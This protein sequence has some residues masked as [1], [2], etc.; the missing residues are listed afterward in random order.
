MDRLDHS[1][2]RANSR[3][4]GL[5]ILRR[6]LL[7]AQSY[8]G[9][10]ERTITVRECIDEKV[11]STQDL[12]VKPTRR[13]L[14]VLLIGLVCA[15]S[16]QIAS[17]CLSAPSE[18]TVPYPELIGRTANIVL[19]RAERAELL[20]DRSVRYLFRTVEVLKGKPRRA[21]T[22]TLDSS[23]I[24]HVRGL[25]TDFDKHRD[26]RFWDRRESRQWNAPDCKMAPNF[27]IGRQYLLFVDK[28][29][30][31]KS[32]EQVTDPDRDRWLQ[33]TRT[34][35]RTGGTQ[36][37]FSQT[38]WEYL[39]EKRA[40]YVDQVK[41]CSRQDG[42][43]DVTPLLDRELIRGERM[44]APNLIRVFTPCREG[45]TFLTFYYQTPSRTLGNAWDFPMPWPFPM[46]WDFLNDDP[47]GVPIEDGMADFTSLETEIKIAGPARISIQELRQRLR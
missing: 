21:F 26:G 9:F 35:I 14:G 34:V 7:I 15:G 23:W 38:V 36:P 43:T 28:P 17:A 22:L 8:F 45:S 27:M 18:Q 5:G 20:P 33:A 4:H 32:F 46:P 40:V 1:V 11:C 42:S 12:P 13:A 47:N 29:Y 44:P 31:R 41:T 25:D 10:F 30:H 3:S 19:A 16:P 39:A 2:R 37:G 6:P 24:T